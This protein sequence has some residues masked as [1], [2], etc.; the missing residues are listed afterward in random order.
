MAVFE[1]LD[2]V[3]GGRGDLAMVATFPDGMETKYYDFVNGK[4]DSMEESRPS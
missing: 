2:M 1:N 4:R 3:L